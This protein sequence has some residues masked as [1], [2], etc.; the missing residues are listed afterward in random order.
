[1]K[2]VVLLAYLPA[3]PRDQDEHPWEAETYRQKSLD[4]IIMDLVRPR[5][6]NGQ[7]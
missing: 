4:H 3:P 2:C 1:M 5:N 7:S 6:C